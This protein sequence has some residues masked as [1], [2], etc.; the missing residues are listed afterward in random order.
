MPKGSEE[1]YFNVLASPAVQRRVGF[2]FCSEVILES[3]EHEKLHCLW[4]TNEDLSKT[5]LSSDRTFLF[6]DTFNF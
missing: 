2:R 3:M 4:V 6:H 1:N 5:F